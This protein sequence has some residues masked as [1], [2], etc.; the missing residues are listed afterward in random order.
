MTTSVAHTSF[1]R[2]SMKLQSKPTVGGLA[3]IW[4][5]PRGRAGRSQAGAVLLREDC[6]KNQ[7][8]K[9]ITALMTS[10]VGEP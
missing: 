5:R 6:S 2:E 1:W 10:L 9:L 4:M 8:S 7:F 3:I